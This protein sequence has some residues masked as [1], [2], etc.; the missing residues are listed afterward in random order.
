MDTTL[1]K[2]TTTPTLGRMLDAISAPLL[3][4]DSLRGA[5]RWRFIAVFLFIT[6]AALLWGGVQHMQTVNTTPYWADQIDY[7]YYAAR[8]AYTGGEYA[9]DFNRAP[10][11][12]WL[13]SLH[14][15]AGEHPRDFQQRGLWLSIVIT[16]ACSLVVFGIFTHYLRLSLAVLGYMIIAFMLYV[17]KAAYVQAEVLYYTASFAAFVLMCELLLRPTWWTAGLL[18]FTVAVAQL[19]KASLTAGLV[20]FV[21][22]YGLKLLVVHGERWKRAAMLGVALG[23]LLVA[24]LPEALRA[25]AVNAPPL[26][27]VNTTF[28]I[29]VDDW[30]QVKDGIQMERP[31]NAYPHHI[32]AEDLPSLRNYLDRNGLDGLLSQT[33]AGLRWQVYNH[34]VAGFGYQHYIVLLGLMSLAALGWLYRADHAQWWA[35]VRVGWPV[36]LFAALFL[37]GYGLLYSFYVP[38]NPGKRFWQALIVPLVWVMLWGLQQ[39]PFWTWRVQGRPVLRIWSAV[40]LLLVTLHAVWAVTV[41]VRAFGGG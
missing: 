25:R 3:W 18:G 32:P 11:F 34:T 37:V 7:Y 29:W 28:Y 40:L 21:V 6:Q 38:I 36:L 35:L 5:G 41:D 19:S 17:F 33:W 20:A 2:H 15:Q 24:L 8:I 16:M 14:Y 26:Y 9:G 27:N 39:P 10:L 12:N 23:V 13:Q 4:L 30:Q 31:Q 1:K 22:V